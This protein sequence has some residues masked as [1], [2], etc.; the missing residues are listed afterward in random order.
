MRVHY[1]VY[2]VLLLFIF[3]LGAMAQFHPRS[4]TVSFYERN[5]GGPRLGVTLIPGSG[6]LAS[7]LKDKGMEPNLLVGGEDVI[8]SALVIAAG[9]SFNYSGVSIPINLVYTTNPVGNRFS[10]I[11][12]Y[13]IK[14]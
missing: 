3:T 14:K 13:A 1:F 2:T 7:K 11:F 10:I 4:E 9:K 6:E 12:G 5:L 8:Y